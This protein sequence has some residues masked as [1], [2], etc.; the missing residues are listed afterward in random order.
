MT[1][2]A[3]T[4]IADVVRELTEP[5]SNDTP[6][7]IADVALAALRSAGYDPEARYEP[8]TRQLWMK[9]QTKSGKLML[10]PAPPVFRRVDTSCTEDAP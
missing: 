6:D 5:G 10:L 3:R 7:D 1:E 9:A 8:E 4:I 2:S